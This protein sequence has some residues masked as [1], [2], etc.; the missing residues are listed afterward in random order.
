MFYT[1]CIAYSIIPEY[2]IIE[3]LIKNGYIVLINQDGNLKIIQ[4]KK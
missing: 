2:D 3:D 1:D 4:R